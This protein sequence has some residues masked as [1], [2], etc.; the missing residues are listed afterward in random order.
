M[1]I[2][3]LH[4][5]TYYYYSIE[6]IYPPR[7]MISKLLS[8]DLMHCYGFIRSVWWVPYVTIAASKMQ[9]NLKESVSHDK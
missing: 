7:G 3:I 8:S 6:R 5:I 9:S 2:G 1:L 4:P